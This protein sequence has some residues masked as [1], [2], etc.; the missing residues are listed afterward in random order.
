[1]NTYKLPQ[2]Y[3]KILKDEDYKLILD[4]Y[5]NKETAYWSGIKKIQSKQAAERFIYE[6]NSDSKVINYVIKDSVTQI[7]IGVF[8]LFKTELF[9]KPT[10][11]IGYAILPQYRNKGC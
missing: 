2:V 1:M 9:R 10:L 11:E 5:S 7:S 8:S 4:L 3:L 6:S